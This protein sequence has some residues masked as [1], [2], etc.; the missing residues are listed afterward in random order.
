MK[1][2]YWMRVQLLRQMRTFGIIPHGCENTVHFN[3]NSKKL[4]VVKAALCAGTPKRI[5]TSSEG[6]ADT[7]DYDTH[8]LRRVNI[9]SATVPHAAI[10][11]DSIQRGPPPVPPGCQGHRETDDPAIRLAVN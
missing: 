7:R 1:M 2:V 5:L 8:H 6:N 3:S 11:Q 4:T 10:Q 9:G